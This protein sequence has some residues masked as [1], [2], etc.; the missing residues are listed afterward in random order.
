LFVGEEPRAHLVVNVYENDTTPLGIGHN[1]IGTVGVGSVLMAGEMDVSR[2]SGRVVPLA[3]D[4]AEAK[5]VVSDLIEEI[6][7]APLDL[8][9]L[10]EG[11][12]HMEPSQPIYDEALTR[13]EAREM[14]EEVR[15]WTTG[16]AAG[17]DPRHAARVAVRA[18]ASCLTIP[19]PRSR[20]DRWGR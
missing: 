18:P 5:S 2:A 17:G 13:Q 14:V 9:S 11:G 20:P 19:R 12:S 10:H 1:H 4:D 8:G 6:G 15:T 3:G 7:F 16:K